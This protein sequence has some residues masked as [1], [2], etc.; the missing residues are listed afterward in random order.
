MGDAVFVQRHRVSFLYDPADHREDI[1]DEKCARQ[2]K[3]TDRLFEIEV[4]ERCE[5]EKKRDDRDNRGTLKKQRR[6]AM[7]T[8]ELSETRLMLGHKT[9]ARVWSITYFGINHFLLHF[10]SFVSSS[11]S[12]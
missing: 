2:D 9:L 8:D 3:V 6:D 4:K 1:N 10:N 12:S 11:L 7:N 5:K